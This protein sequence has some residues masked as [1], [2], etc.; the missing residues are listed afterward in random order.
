M[1]GFYIGKVLR[2]AI[3]LWLGTWHE[4]AYRA[5]FHV[6]HGLSNAMLLPVVTEFSI[7]CG[8]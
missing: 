3:H 1:I 7:P 6:P 8:T 2:F 4:P 5:F